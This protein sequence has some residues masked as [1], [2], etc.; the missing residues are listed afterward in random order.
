[1]PCGVLGF[2]PPPAELPLFPLLFG[3]GGVT[4]GLDGG[5]LPLD[6]LLFSFLSGAGFAFS[7]FFGS[8]VL[9]ELFPV[10]GLLGVG[11]TCGVEGLDVE[12]LDGLS[13]GLVVDE[14]LPALP[15]LF[16]VF[17]VGTEGFS[18]DVLGVLDSCFPE[19]SGFLFS[20]LLGFSSFFLG[21]TFS[22]FL[23]GSSF[24]CTRGSPHQCQ[25]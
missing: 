24:F 25:G 8:V 7:G 9:P 17:G 4:W 1:M 2:D 13:A 14:P 3:T 16:G 11:V 19:F 10:L 22:L 6:E 20:G 5:V 18:V 21:S 15:L 23:V 12:P